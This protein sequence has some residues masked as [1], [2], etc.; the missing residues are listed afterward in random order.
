MCISQDLYSYNKEQAEGDTFNTI[1]VVIYNLGI[2][3][4][5]A[6]DWLE[7]EHT[8]LL[9]GFLDE[10]RDLPSF[11]TPELDVRV[12]RWVNDVAAM[13]R[14]NTEWHFASPRYFGKDGALVC[15]RGY[16]DL[17]PKRSKGGLPTPSSTS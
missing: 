17:L 1:S 11:G 3:L 14:G 2:D 4:D 16:V 6:V 7:A 8:R 13:V 12:R 10:L 9:N 5:S 15:Q